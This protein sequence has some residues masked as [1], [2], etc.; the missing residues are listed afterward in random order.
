MNC[1]ICRKKI[2]FYGICN[3][4]IKFNEKMRGL[5]RD[6]TGKMAV[7]TGGRIKVGYAVCLRLLRQNAS[8]IAITRYPNVALQNY[9]NEPD[10]NDFKDRLHIIGFDLTYVNK[11][12]DLLNTIYSISNGKVDILINNAAQTVRKSNE[13]YTE[14]KDKDN[15]LRLEYNKFQLVNLQYNNLPVLANLCS[16]EYG[17]TDFDNSWVRK[18]ADISVREMLEVQLINVTAPFILT[19]RIADSMMNHSGKKFIINVSSVEGKFMNKP[20]RHLHT[21][22]AKASLNMMTLTLANMYKLRDIYIYAA[23]PGWVSNQFPPEYKYTKQFTAYLSFDDGA[24]RVL[25]PIQTNMLKDKIKD[26]GSFY[27][28][29]KIINY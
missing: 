29:Y 24:A 14:L 5:S 13:Y 23:D 19:T 11:M 28:D 20:A 1:L 18:P 17:E 4:C 9:I 16:V 3:D 7:V 27:K 2:D 22:M 25:Y 8:V 10:Y 12:D 21:N 15:K 6:L 26:A